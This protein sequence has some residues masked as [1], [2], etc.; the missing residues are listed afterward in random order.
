MPNYKYVCVEC[1]YTEFVELP[2]SYD[3][4][5]LFACGSCG[6]KMTR[7]IIGGNFKIGKETLGAW[8]K[9]KTGKEFMGD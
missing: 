6:F 1:E 8:Y 5:A 3:P 9:K 7:R 2:I 4:K